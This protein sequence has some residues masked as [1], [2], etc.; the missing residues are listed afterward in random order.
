[1]T[2]LRM[3]ALASALMLCLSG[4]A[5]A[6]QSVAEPSF[7]VRSLYEDCKGR[8]VAFCDGYLSGIADGLEKLRT[9]NAKWADE[10]CPAPSEDI[11]LYREVFM[12][13]A[14]RSHL[15]QATPYDGACVAFWTAWFCPNSKL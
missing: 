2:S 3:V 13:W 15:W 8:D 6:Q 4:S 9:F 14:E 5:A 7:S 11:S 12:S 10:Y 1:M